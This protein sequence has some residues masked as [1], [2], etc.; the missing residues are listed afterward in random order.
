MIALFVL[1]R[2]RP[3]YSPQYAIPLLGM[4]LGHTLNG[5]ALGLDRFGGE[6]IA[7]RAQVEALLAA[8]PF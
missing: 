7:Q 3:W 8:L 6:L 4:I 2:V 5:I 1:V